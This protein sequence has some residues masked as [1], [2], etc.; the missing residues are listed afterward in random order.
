MDGKGRELSKRSTITK[1]IRLKGNLGVLSKDEDNTSRHAKEINMGM[2]GGKKEEL[3]FKVIIIKRVRLE[4][5]KKVE[6]RE[7]LGRRLTKKS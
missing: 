2:N 3:L 6:L 4:T 5:S 7:L 1:N